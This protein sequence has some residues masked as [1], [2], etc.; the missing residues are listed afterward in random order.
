MKDCFTAMSKSAKAAPLPTITKSSLTEGMAPEIHIS[1]QITVVANMMAFGNYPKNFKQFGLNVRE[2]R[3]LGCIAQMGPLTGRQIVD[4]AHQDKANIS[5]AIAEL[6]KKGLVTKLDNKLHKRSPLIWMTVEGQALYEQIYPTLAQ[7]AEAFT[8]VLSKTEKKQFCEVLDR[9][10][11]H[12]EVVGKQ[13]GL[14]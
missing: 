11:Q 9:L 4:E 1:Y 5:R 2:W 10:K 7:Q 13:E 12:I 8:E 3:V 6:E 14:A